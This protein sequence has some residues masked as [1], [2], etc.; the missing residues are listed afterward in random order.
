MYA[1]TMHLRENHYRSIGSIP[2][3]A[4]V[5]TKLVRADSMAEALEKLQLGDDC[6]K[7]EVA[8][9]LDTVD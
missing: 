6:T 2:T 4:C 9:V 3:D 1:I 7:V 5:I 8:F